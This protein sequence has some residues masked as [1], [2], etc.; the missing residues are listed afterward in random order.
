MDAAARRRRVVASAVVAVGVALSVC[1]GSLVFASSRSGGTDARTGIPTLVLDAYQRAAAESAKVSP[2]CHLKW[3]LLAAI[4]KM[5]SDHADGGAVLPN[6]VMMT[7]L[8]GAPVTFKPWRPAKPAPSATRSASPKP[9][10]R[11]TPKPSPTPTFELIRAMGPMQF[12]PG[13]WRV[14]GAGGDPQNVNDATRAAARLLCAGGHDLGDPARLDAAV[15]RYNHSTAY[16][17]AVKAAMAKYATST[18]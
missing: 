8:F 13:T 14:Y 7:P 15:L 12:L 2:K 4:G 1:A 6:G 3:E 17:A 11:L 18:R 16:L 9:S 10:S 5:E